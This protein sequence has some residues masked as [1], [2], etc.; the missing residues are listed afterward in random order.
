KVFGR[1]PVRGVRW[2]KLEYRS[3]PTDLLGAKA[4][5][6]EIF[7]VECLDPQKFG[8]TTVVIEP[9]VARQAQPEPVPEAQPAPSQEPP[10]QLGPPAPT[11]ALEQKKE[12]QAASKMPR[13]L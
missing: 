11:P 12:V 6:V 2:D 9:L 8:E 10:Q 3:A 13:K 1:E 7:G 4:T 5:H